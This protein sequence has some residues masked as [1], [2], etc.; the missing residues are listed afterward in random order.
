MTGGEAFG[1]PGIPPT[2]AS[3]DKDFVTTSLG[4]ARVW[5]SIGH[6]NVNEIYWP[7]T[8]RPEIR[9]F[10]F[11]LIGGGHWVDLKRVCNYTLSKPEPYLPLLTV[12]H[13]G[14]DYR[15]TLEVLPDPHRDVLLVRYDLEGPYKLG[16]IAAPHLGES[17]YDNDAWVDGGLL[18]ASI[19]ARAVCI[20]ADAPMEDQSVGF[21]GASDGWQD[22]NA[23]NRFTY[24]FTSA[25]GG[26]IAMSAALSAPKGV[27][28]LGIAPHPTGARTLAMSSLAQGYD[29]VRERFLAGWEA[30]GSKLSLPAPEAD[31]AEE[32]LTTATVLRTHEDRMFPGAVVAS[33]ST[34]WGNSTNT[35]G[36]YHLVW[37]RDA[38]LAA[39]ALLA[40]NQVEDARRM[41]AHMIGVQQ[42]DGHWTQNYFPDGVPFWTGIQL[43]EAA[44]PV[45]LAAKLR[46]LGQ[47]DLPGTTEMV[48]RAIAF[49]AKAGPQSDQDRWEENPGISAFTIPVLIAALVAAAPWLDEATRGYALDLADDWNERIEEW[50]YVTGTPMAE[51]LGV[52]GYYVRIAPPEMDGGVTGTLMLRNRNGETIRACAL[53]A[54]DFSYI[55]RL[56]LRSATD[57]K[58]KDTIKV[59]DEVLK[60]DTPS[61]PVYRRYNED[62]Y[63]EHDDGS[64][65]DGNGVGRAWPLLVGERGHLALQAGEDP[66]LYLKTMRNCAS[67]GG[68][69]PEQVWDAAPI[70]ERHL[71]PGR[72]S[73]S[74]M[75]LVWSHA[76][77]LK[78]LIARQ[79]GRPV[80]LLEAVAKRYGG[81]VPKAKYTRWRNEVPVPS[82]CQGRALIIEDREPFTLHL[83]WDGWQDVADVPAQELPFG[84]W[85]V[86]IEPER[87]AGRKELNF[88]R[89]YT[90]GWEGKNHTVE[91]AATEEQ[92]TLTHVSDGAA[93]A[94]A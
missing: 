18:Y 74:A 66:L 60:V 92:R 80:E 31:L 59:V 86:A 43:D 62:G 4:T 12:T 40:A 52:D 84:L 78:L 81:S 55:V 25:T 3:S 34:P 14:D 41:L 39:F 79:A 88:T 64:P 29:T 22:L 27:I 37:P 77:F 72:P 11:Y 23:H 85:G 19:P 10:G 75:P 70:P 7:S 58:I 32:A 83:G 90:E 50:C 89:R 9:D 63:G 35:L 65:Y 94:K 6:G 26:N 57:P 13:T 51:K 38:T 76:E 71:Y 87:Y 1:A 73:G 69:L 47:P 48:R 5:A 33:M 21:V 68:L 16:I 36:G 8:G 49:I 44:F 15:L 54:L 91:I 45:M 24:G 20:G 67:P 2:W 82:L 28:A 93:A 46:E 17:G 56:G 42:P 30:W 61:G 53:V